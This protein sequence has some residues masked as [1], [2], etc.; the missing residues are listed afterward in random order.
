MKRGPACNMRSKDVGGLFVLVLNGH[1]GRWVFARMAGL[2]LE[3]VQGHD[4][5]CEQ[6]ISSPN[7]IK[8]WT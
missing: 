1:Y 5:P 7:T 8:L 4:W 2:V 3:V 6:R